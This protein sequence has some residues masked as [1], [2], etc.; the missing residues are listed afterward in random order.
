MRITEIRIWQHDLMVKG[1]VYQM[2]TSQ[3]DRLDTTVVEV[4][5]DTGISG[6]GETCP[7]GS[8]YQPQF[9]AGARAA[10]AEVGP[11]VL[12]MDPRLIG[13]VNERM[14]AVLSG[15]LYAKAAID[16]ACWDLLGKS[17]G[18]RVCDLLGGA[19]DDTVRSYW[20]IMPATPEAT[21]AKAAEL[22]ADGYTRLQ[23]KTGGRPLA[24]DIACVRAVAETLQPGVPLTADANRGWTARDA[25]EFS[26]ALRD[27]GLALEQPCATLEEHR[28]LVGRV[29]HPVFLDESATDLATVIT[30]IG[31][32]LAQGFGMKLSRVG[33]LTKLRAVRDVC[34]AKGIPTTIDDTWGGDL[35]A[36]ATVH[37]GSTVRP[38][39]YEGTWIS[40]PY[41]SSGYA[42]ISP[43]I[44]PVNG[45]IPVPTGPGLGVEP[46]LDAWGEPE[47]RIS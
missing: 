9:A 13:L 47:A 36:A 38:D 43:S 18:M 19:H 27:V 17:M 6:F 45:R 42:T 16:V 15:H 10:L 3:V 40:E 12:G 30:A 7:L 20:G 1:G 25:L 14:D 5:A 4:V 35:T 8:A 46:D 28:Q 39:L 2:S 24:D 26:I 29:A 23:V 21:A 34:E 33:G 32:G 37:M 44:V 31:D 11:A 22:Q 41:T